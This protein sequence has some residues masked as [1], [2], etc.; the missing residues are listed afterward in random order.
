MG[1]SEYFVDEHSEFNRQHIEGQQI[2]QAFTEAMAF[3]QMD[4]LLFSK[5][6]AKID[7]VFKERDDLSYRLSQATDFIK[8]QGT[9][10]E[11]EQ[12]KDHLD[13]DGV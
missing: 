9:M 10:A 6:F 12:Y 13:Y 11:F 7:M 8:K 4:H 3:G 1:M 5:L 2:R